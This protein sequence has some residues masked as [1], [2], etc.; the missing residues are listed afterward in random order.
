MTTW[1]NFFGFSFLLFLPLQF[2]LAQ[3]PSGIVSFSFD[4]ETAPVWDLTGPLN[5]EQ[6]LLGSGSQ[7]IPLAFSLDVTQDIR[8]KLTGSGVALVTV[9]NDV[10]AGPYTLRGAVRGGGSAP[11]RASITVTMA[12]EDVV[13]GINTRFNI[14]IRYNLEASSE[15]LAFVGPAS[16]SAKFKA[17]S[18]AKIKS[19][20]SVPLAGGMDGSWTAQMNIIP[21]RRL[22]GSASII[23][24]NGR[25]LPTQLT[26]SYSSSS[27]L[28][29]VKLTGVNEAKGVSANLKFIRSAEGIE[30]QSLK[31]KI[32]GQ[33][34]RQ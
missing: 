7:E 29:S 8:G 24:S 27:A 4:N 5:F 23:L 15:D 12:G 22:G 10:I 33:T 13:A 14:N 19:D 1:K 25:T 32:L 18:S 26:G 28:A 30:L 11:V 3:A 16:G 2:C 6:A 34:V 17:L 31:G 21:L 20:V 9:G